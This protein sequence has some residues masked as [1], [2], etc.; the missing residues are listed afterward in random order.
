MKPTPMDPSNSPSWQ[1][2][3]RLVFGIILLVF[4]LGLVM[5]LRQMIA[6]LVLAFLLACASRVGSLS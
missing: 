3:T 4:A 2:G 6:P 5:L 1:P